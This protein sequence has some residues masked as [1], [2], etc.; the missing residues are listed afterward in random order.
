[1]EKKEASKFTQMKNFSEALRNG[2]LKKNGNNLYIGAYSDE[3]LYARCGCMDCES[4]P[5]IANENNKQ[6][7][8]QENYQFLRNTY[9][10]NK[11]S[12]SVHPTLWNNGT[13][14]VLSGV[15][16][17]LP[18][19][20]YQIRGYDMAN[21]TFVKTNHI[22]SLDIKENDEWL[23]MDTLMSEECTQAAM[24]VF[25]GY[26][27]YC[28]KIYNPNYQITVSGIIISHSHVDHFGGMGIV[29]QYCK[30]DA[31]IYAPKGFLEASVSENVYAGNAMSRRASYQYGSF[32]KPQDK[33]DT[34]SSVSIGI[35]QGQ[36]TGTVGF[37]PATEEIAETIAKRKIETEGD[38][39]EIIFQLTPGTEA[40]AEMNCYFPQYKALWLA[41]N[42]VGTLHN[43][44]TLRG[45]QIRDGNA[46]AKYLVQSAE[47]YGDKT[48]VIF[49]SHN[50]PHWKEHEYE[51]FDNKGNVTGKEIRKL[52]LKNFILDTASMYKYI[53]DQT[54][55]YMNEGYKMNEVADMLNIPIQMQK[56]WCLKP[57][58][59]T[60]KHNAKAVYQKY[61]GWYDANPLHLT[62]LPSEQL[63][64]ELVRYMD[65]SKTTLESALEDYE[66]GNYWTAAYMAYQLVIGS[67]NKSDVEKATEL[68]ADS[69][70]QLGYQAESGTWRNAYLAS[71][72]ELRQKQIWTYSANKEN[73]QG[74]QNNLT[75]NMTPE[76]IL[77][78]IGILLDGERVN[79]ADYIDGVIDITEMVGKSVTDKKESRKHNYFWCHMR[80]GVI[81]YYPYSNENSVNKYEGELLFAIKKEELLQLVQAT[82][83][84]YSKDKIVAMVKSVLNS[85]PNGTV[86]MNTIMTGMVNLSLPRF[87]QFDIINLHDGEVRIRENNQ[88]NGKETRSEIVCNI[89]QEVQNCAFMLEAYYNSMRNTKKEYLMKLQPEDQEK[90]KSYYNLLKKR[91][92]ILT[93]GDFFICGIDETWGIGTDVTFNK[94]E[95]VHVLYECYRY[96]AAPYVKNNCRPSQKN[97][98]NQD[99]IELIYHIQQE[100][101]M[102]EPYIPQ[103]YQKGMTPGVKELDQ[104]DATAWSW[105]FTNIN[106]RNGKE[107]ILDSSFFDIDKGINPYCN[108]GIG[109]DGKFEAWELMHFLYQLHRK[110]YVIAGG[111]EI[112]TNYEDKT[113]ISAD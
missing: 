31:P 53:N 41:E 81:L 51:I 70:E 87:R 35:G 15:F 92:G 37:L 110:L 58:Y 28:T 103:F 56:N 19:R 21:I 46:W 38:C 89:K 44:Y 43:L 90:W 40:P 26:I 64:K 86:M 18:G 8:S 100:I 54:L 88:V 36:S 97:Q 93:D 55:L 11:E 68:C 17:V 71:A 39:L 48:E 72:H 74:N 67:S 78:Y 22:E 42:C 57:F 80:N 62:E 98:L 45:T 10:N 82:Q 47:L 101:L 14:N 69:L 13:N 24:S 27:L 108:M 106:N 50:W 77:D 65:S 73:L 109:I 52:D 6:V 25:S 107:V 76:M 59:G 49:Q 34:K 23:V 33:N 112:E 85:Q 5:S 91:C 1:M 79:G 66:V 84:N 20:I 4:V 111:I 83:Q 105:Y 7:W 75:A 95:Y 94:Y 61:L 102:L 29:K 32:I 99:E 96:L 30:K 104:A 12:L 16:E 3:Y 9:Q 60:P 113:L 63:A 2:I